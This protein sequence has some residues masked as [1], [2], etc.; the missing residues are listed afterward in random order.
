M[1]GDVKYIGDIICGLEEADISRLE[2]KFFTNRILQVGPLY[3]FNPST[4]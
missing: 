4:L 3:L 1:L 2:D